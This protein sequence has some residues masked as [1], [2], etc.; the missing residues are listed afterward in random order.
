M[1]HQNKSTFARLLLCLFL[2]VALS[3]SSAIAKDSFAQLK[4]IFQKTLTATHD[5]LF[6]NKYITV[7]VMVPAVDGVM[8]TKT[9]IVYRSN[10]KNCCIESLDTAT[11]IKTI[12]LVTPTRVVQLRVNPDG[13]S[14]L[15]STSALPS[16]A[17]LNPESVLWYKLDE[18]LQEVGIGMF[19]YGHYKKSLAEML[20]DPKTPSSLPPNV[21]IQFGDTIVMSSSDVKGGRTVLSSTPY[22]LLLS[23][24]KYDPNNKITIF[25]KH[26]FDR[27]RPTASEVYIANESDGKRTNLKKTVVT[28]WEE[29]TH[30]DSTFK[31]SQYGLPDL[32]DGELPPRAPYTLYAG[33]TFAA[34]VLA[35]LASLLL[36]RSRHR[37][38]GQGT[39]S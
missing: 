39:P 20:L 12:T 19:Q 29:K 8:F 23:S 22:T 4:E 2:S 1:F 7:D 31:L 36:L 27:Q 30:D 9:S 26:S 10:T 24:E 5:H 34:L 25:E 16:E 11:K 33:L 3:V 13:Q 6:R 15:T 17:I 14:V 35:G 18:S 37:N 32:D 28:H 21:S 38:R